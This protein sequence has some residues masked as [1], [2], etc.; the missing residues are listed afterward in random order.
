MLSPHTCSCTSHLL[1]SAHTCTAQEAGV[2]SVSWLFHLVGKSQ[3]N[4][5]LANS[6][7]QI[8]SG[9]WILSQVVCSRSPMSSR[10]QPSGTALTL[11]GAAK[12][13][14]GM[15][16]LQ[17]ARTARLGTAVP[18]GLWEPP[19]VLTATPQTPALPGSDHVFL[20]PSPSCPWGDLR[21]VTKALGDTQNPISFH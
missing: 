6:F 19:P 14:R 4:E 13:C 12:Y 18:F 7:W 20:P 21:T 5:Q 3:S 17:L 11:H 15:Q 8:K 10:S 9:D 1:L 16:G 2:R